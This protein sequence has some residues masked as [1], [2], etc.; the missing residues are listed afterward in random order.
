[1]NILKKKAYPAKLIIIDS[2]VDLR[3]FTFGKTM[4]LN[5]AA[6]IPLEEYA[7]LLQA[8]EQYEKLT[9]LKP[10]AD[11]IKQREMKS[12]EDAAYDEEKDRKFFKK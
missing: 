12:M 2:F 9:M 1:M 11:A 4:T 3:L 8:A 5:R 10:L 6:I 7:A